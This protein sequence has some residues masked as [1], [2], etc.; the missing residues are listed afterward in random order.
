M[1]NAHV[2]IDQ[3]IAGYHKQNNKQ[4][5]SKSDMN[6]A[7]VSIDQNHELNRELPRSG[8]HTG[9]VTGHLSLL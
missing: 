2:S 8:E 1:N 5:N 3:N 9:H 7:H 6:N 4:N